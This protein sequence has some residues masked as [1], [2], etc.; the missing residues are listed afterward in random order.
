MRSLSY[1]YTFS[2]SM[3]KA[4]II[5]MTTLSLLDSLQVEKET[6]EKWEMVFRSS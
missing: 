1:E 3:L 5:T 4:E 6:E 2:S